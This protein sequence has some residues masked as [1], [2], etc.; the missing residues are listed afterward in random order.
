MI[1][2]PAPSSS[3]RSRALALGAALLLVASAAHAGKKPPA[4]PKPPPPPPPSSSPTTP[5]NLRAT[6]ATAY[7]VSFTWGASTDDSG[8][9]SYRL[10]NQTRGASI[11]VPQ[12]QTTFTWLA[13]NL[14]PNQ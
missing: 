4:P 8:V 6:A 2:R 12:A 10:V 13:P 7:S 11:T 1:G 3:L 9:L 5:S 14:G